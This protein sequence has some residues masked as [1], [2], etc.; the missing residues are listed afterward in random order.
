MIRRMLACGL[1]AGILA[2]GAQPASPATPRPEDR[3]APAAFA[4]PEKERAPR[5]GPAEATS[6]CEEAKEAAG[7][8]RPYGCITRI[9]SVRQ[10][11]AA[12]GPL[13]AAAGVPLPTNNCTGDEDGYWYATRTWMCE[14]DPNVHYTYYDQNNKWLGAATFAVAQQ[15][16]LDRLSLTWKETDQVKMIAR[17]GTL[18][19]NLSI[20]WTTECKSACA[21][22]STKVWEEQPVSLGQNLEKTYSVTNQPSQKYDF[23]DHTYKLDI[24]AAGTIPLTEPITWSGSR[25]RCDSKQALGNTSGCVVAWFTPTLSV[26]RAKFGSSADMIAWA[27]KNLSGHWGLKG[28]GKPLSR[29]QNAQQQ[30]DNRRRVCETAWTPDQTVAEVT[31]D[32]FPFASSYESGALNGIQNGSE[33]AQV[34]AVQKDSTGVLATD[35]PTV[36]TIG[37]VTGKEVCVRGHIPSSLNTGVGSYYVKLIREARL[38]DKDE[39]WVQVTA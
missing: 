22:N 33:C 18:P 38:A 4:A 37:T 12:S 35:W 34:K 16:D 9:S 10:A 17:E 24:H 1:A 29:L 15:L 28:T 5:G 6:T 7:G 19:A 8:N 26:S 2:F 36:T 20:S 14:I 13:R 39:F 3:T 27:Q 32:E 31:C 25:F 23:I 11:D 21:P 30:K